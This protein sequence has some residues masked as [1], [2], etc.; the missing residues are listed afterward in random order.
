MY[1]VR[2]VTL[3]A[4]AAVA[5]AP[6]GAQGIPRGATSR[7]TATV[8]NAPRFMVANP[9]AFA[10]AD[11]A[12]AVAIGTSMRD[13]MKGSRRSGLRVV[14]Q[15]QMNDALKQ[16]GYPMD[17]ILSP[18]LATT[19]AKNI[20]A[21]VLVTSTMAK[22]EGR[23]L[24]RYGPAGRRQRRRGQCRHAHPGCRARAREAF[25]KQRGP[26]AGARGRSRSPTP[27]PASTSGPPSPTRRSTPPTRRS[28][29]CPTMAWLDFCLAQIA[30][31][32]KAPRAEV[33]KHLQA[34]VKGDPA[35]PAGLD[36][37]GRPQYQ[38]ANDTANTLVAFKQM[39]RVAP[40]NQKLR[41]ELFKY[42][43]P[44]G[45]PGDGA[46]GSGRGA[47]ARSVQ[48][49]SVRPEEQ[50]LSLPQ[51]LQVRGG[52]A[53][54]HVRHR[55]H[56]GRHALLHQDL[57]P[58]PPR[59]RS[60]TP[61][62]C[63]S[64]PRPASRK[65]PDNLTLLGYLNRAYAMRADGQRGR[66]HE[67]IIA[68]GHHRGGPG[69]RGRSGP[70]RTAQRVP[71]HRQHQRIYRCGAP[72]KP[73]AAGKEALPFLEFA[74]KHGDAQA[75]ENAAALLYTGRAPLLQEPQ[76]LEGAA[77]LL[78]HGGSGCEPD[79][80]GVSGGELSAG[81]GNAVSGAG[82][83]RPEAEKTEVLR[84]G[85]AGAGP[86][87]RGRLSALTAGRT[88]NPEA[89]EKNLGIIKQYKPRVASM[90]KAYCKGG[91]AAQDVAP[92]AAR[93]FSPGIAR[94]RRSLGCF[95]PRDEAALR[96]P[97]ARRRH[98]V[99]LWLRRFRRLRRPPIFRPRVLG[100]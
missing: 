67:P 60:R 43:L 40:T 25:G 6:L 18:A 23:P 63:S 35:E 30:K 14:E 46:R 2:L 4:L 56:Q 96:V 33:V 34:A 90:L 54:D 28:R 38:A 77:E 85:Q 86:A 5:T 65:Y 21:R 37:A 26:G 66:G 87:G 8:A 97:S 15:S 76:D 47:Q 82:Q 89:A 51:R 49:R 93:D 20:Q 58:P 62:G 70:D 99:L 48:R 61:S 3:T 11:S 68:E 53:G 16:Y 41:E 31:D 100:L 12:P 44:V 29:A 78:R 27:R 36:R 19:L 94:V 45:T 1:L 59:E 39:L 55:L 88:V 24:R 17:A 64:G 22:G 50:R 9:F 32:K 52:C 79:G 80:Q 72:L 13:E 57:A 83:D 69:A 42:F 71:R 95:A 81:P 74:I 92:T 75:K 84:R 98:A 91:K 7:G 73:R 10:P